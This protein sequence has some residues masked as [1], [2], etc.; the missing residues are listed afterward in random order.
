[1][2]VMY[3]VNEGNYQTTSL[4]RAKCFA[5]KV[6]ARSVFAYTTINGIEV[7]MYIGTF[8]SYTKKSVED[9][10]RVEYMEQIRK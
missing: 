10:L 9:N 3:K 6:G 8:T 5:K 2:N 4:L 7:G 1:M